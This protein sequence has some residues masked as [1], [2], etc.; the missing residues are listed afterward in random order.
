MSIDARRNFALSAVAVA[1]SPPGSGLALVLNAG[2]GEIMPEP[3]FNATVW[4]PGVMP[5]AS[6]AE[7]V[8]VESISQDS[9]ALSARE[10]EETSAKQI[11]PGWQFA[12]MLTAKTIE[13]LKILIETGSSAAKAE[14]AVE[15][16][17]AE[18]AEAINA[19]AITTETSRAEGVES[20]LSTGISTAKGETAT[21]KARAETAEATKASTTALT[22]ETARAEAAE[23]LLAPLASPALTGTPKAPTQPAKD[24]TTAIATDQFVQTARGEAEA[25]SE[26]VAEAAAKVVSEAEVAVEKTR[27][28]TAEGLLA[29]KASPAL[30]GTPTAPTAAAKT[31]TTQLATMAAVQVAKGEAETSS[32]PAGTAAADVKVEKER[33]EAAE[34]LK[35]PLASPALTG[36]PTAPTAAEVTSNTQL[37]TTAFAHEVAT[38]AK[39]AAEAASDKAGAAAT[40]KTEAE[41]ASDKSGAAAA[42]SAEVIGTDPARKAPAV[43][44]G[45]VPLLSS[46]VTGSAE[47]PGNLAAS[48]S[49]AVAQNKEAWLYGTLTQN[50]TVTLTGIAVGARAKLLLTQDGTGGHTLTISDGTHTAVAPINTEKEASVEVDVYSPD[51]STLYVSVP[52]VGISGFVTLAELE[53]YNIKAGQLPASVVTDSTGVVRAA[54]PLYVAPYFRGAANNYQIQQLFIGVSADGITWRSYQPPN[55]ATYVRNASLL[56]HN[57]LWWL[58]YSN[59]KIGG[60]DETFGL[61]T[62]PDLINWT[63]IG[64]VTVTGQKPVWTPNWFVDSDGSVHILVNA[65]YEMH[66]TNEA[67]TAWSAPKELPGMENTALDTV[68]VIKAPG[69]YV[70]FAKESGGVTYIWKATATALHGTWSAWTKGDWAGWGD[71]YEA[72]QVINTGNSPNPWRIY[73]DRYGQGVTYYSDSADLVTWTTAKPVAVDLVQPRALHPSKA[74][75]P[76]SQLTLITLLNKIQ[77]EQAGAGDGP[78]LRKAGIGPGPPSPGWVWSTQGSGQAGVARGH[79]VV[80]ARNMRITE[81]AFA[82]S[83]KAEAN[84]E[85]D[86]GI[87]DEGFNL[88]GHSGAVKGVI[89]GATGRKY[90]PLIAPVWLMAGRSYFFVLSFQETGSTA[91]IRTASWATE[92]PLY[93]V[94]AATPDETVF[95]EKGMMPL[96]ADASLRSATPVVGWGTNF[97]WAIAGIEG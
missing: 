24:N 15:Q 61:A 6:N 7:I 16:A 60:E 90:V 65:V 39:A 80:P 73:M 41:A 63:Q 70:A 8:R 56:W 82:L 43:G 89:N 47:T 14:V 11:E 68:V 78:D 76:E 28:E 23:S 85:I 22:A 87:Y 77:L 1:P 95:A 3:P 64:P 27:A 94:T 18:A 34:N 38:T 79:R 50:T 48:T 33:A 72:P 40:A 13:D 88:L 35:A 29:P 45:S 51:G 74:V 69:E 62:S 96:P 5:T 10:E 42:V 86:I 93:F 54:P 31:N 46:V 66:P 26:S 17:R 52:G 59:E 91:E 71:G 37:A 44:G 32:D 67:M 81:L 25:A 36:T 53:A 84:G 20:A 19:T 57:G 2:G 12:D 30:T 21:E 4:P 92:D 49:L 58:A 75:T 97:A 55:F 83:A 9:V